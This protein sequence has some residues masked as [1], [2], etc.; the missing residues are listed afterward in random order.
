[1]IKLAQ[2][3]RKKVIW[4]LVI[5]LGSLIFTCV[6]VC[7]VMFFNQEVENRNLVIERVIESLRN[8]IS[9]GSYVEIKSRLLSHNQKIPKY[10]LDFISSNFQTDLCTDHQIRKKT[11]FSFFH[12]KIQSKINDDYVVLSN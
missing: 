11:L 2:F 3:L 10:C 4:P 12:Q 8:P 5:F 6:L 9:L 1:V 7:I